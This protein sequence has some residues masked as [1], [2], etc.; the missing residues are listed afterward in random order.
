M[1]F[2]FKDISVKY[3]KKTVLSDVNIDFPEGRIVTLIGKNGC[4]KSSLL[5]TVSRAVTPCAGTP[6]FRDKPLK[7]YKSKLLAKEI[8]Y[9]PQV[10]SSPPDI[11]VKTLVSYGRFPYMKMGRPMTKEDSD[12]IEEAISFT[13]LSQY[14]ERIVSSLSGGERQRAWIAMT[15]CRRPKVLIL[16]E[17]TTYLDISYQVEVLELVKRLN[18]E[19]GVTIIMVLHDLNLAARYSDLLYVIKGGGVYLK[20]PPKEVLTAENIRDVFEIEAD[21]FEDTKNGCPFFIPLKS[22]AA[23]PSDSSI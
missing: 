19:K 6:V 1:F 23:D 14:K 9:L 21:V 16:D 13:G 4:G 7:E 2:G 3:G 18:E 5:K 20:G 11:D 12:A 22:V 17:P 15:V 8:A 10:H